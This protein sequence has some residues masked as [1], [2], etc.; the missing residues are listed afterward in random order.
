VD[1]D[2]RP[3]TLALAIEHMPRPQEALSIRDPSILLRRM[4]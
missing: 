4:L 3:A 1:A 2:E